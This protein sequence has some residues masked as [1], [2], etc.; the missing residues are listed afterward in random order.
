MLAPPGVPVLNP[1]F[2]AT[3]MANITALI[4][5]HGVHRPPL[6]FGALRQKLKL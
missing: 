2:D 5:E 1:A 4:T 3:P 6:D